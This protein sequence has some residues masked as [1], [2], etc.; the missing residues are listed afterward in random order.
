M[1]HALLTAAVG[2]SVSM[3][4]PMYASTAALAQTSSSTTPWPDRSIRLV[5]P[6]PAGSA[7]DVAVRLIETQLT[8]QLGQS[9]VVDNRSGASGAIG[10]D[11]VAKAQPD[12]YMVGLIT[13]STHAVASS[14]GKKLPYDPIAD[15]TPVGM[16]GSTPYVLVTYPGL[17]VRNLKDLVALAKAKPGALNYGSAGPASMAH[18]AAALLGVDAGID[19]VHVPYRSSVHAVTDI[20][21]G[22]IQMQFATIPPS[23]ELIATGK[24]TAVAVSGAKRS[25]TLPDVATVAEQGIPGFEAG[26]WMALVMPPKTPAAIARRFNEVLNKVLS[27]GKMRETLLVQGLETEPGPPENVTH[28]IR[29]DVEKW[30]A[31][32][33]KAGIKAD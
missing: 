17:G 18:L 10:V 30:R 6:F 29:T 9:V 12:G 15:Q 21:A 1:K 11:A 33:T 23:A 22:R 5:V 26:L 16:I 32:I 27:D 25:S 14:L 2:L 20:M 13:V 28:R 19:I 3:S 7:T 31:V 4:A 24:L 8:P